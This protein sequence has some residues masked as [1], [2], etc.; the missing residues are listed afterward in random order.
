MN[1]VKHIFFTIVIT[2]ALCIPATSHAF[3]KFGAVAHDPKTGHVVRLLGDRHEY[4]SKDPAEKQFMKNA[5]PALNTYLTTDAPEIFVVEAGDN[6]E[7]HLQKLLEKDCCNNDDL[8]SRLMHLAV[9]KK[10]NFLMR[11]SNDEFRLCEKPKIACTTYDLRLTIDSNMETLIEKLSERIRTYSSQYYLSRINLRAINLLFASLKK[12]MV[13]LKNTIDKNFDAIL[14]CPYDSVFTNCFRN[15]YKNK[16]TNVLWS[17]MEMLDQLIP[18]DLESNKTQIITIL[19]DLDKALTNIADLGFLACIGKS[20]MLGKNITLYTGA[21][22]SERLLEELKTMGY[23]VLWL[24]D[25]RDMPLSKEDCE[26]F[27]TIKP[28]PNVVNLKAKL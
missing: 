21:N 26:T 11:L 28:Q 17:N 22:H 7:A 3:G 4:S 6:S 27:F 18:T 9:A 19:N 23:E 24:K 2:G 15:Y 20:R 10:Q 25:T 1:A 16:I 5:I 14:D 8:M 12:R 13:L